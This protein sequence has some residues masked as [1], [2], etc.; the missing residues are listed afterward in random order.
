VVPFW[1][2]MSKGGE[3]VIREETPPVS[4]RCRIRGCRKF[5]QALDRLCNRCR[6]ELVALSNYYSLQDAV[7][8]Q[9]QQRQEEEQPTSAA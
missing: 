1:A 9:E 2:N 4:V 7:E 8:A 5:T 6:E 3:S